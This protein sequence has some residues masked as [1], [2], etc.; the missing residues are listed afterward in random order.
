MKERRRISPEERVRMNE[1]Y[2]LFMDM[3]RRGED[4]EGRKRKYHAA[5]VEA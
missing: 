2:E 1:V 5:K 4:R 3:L